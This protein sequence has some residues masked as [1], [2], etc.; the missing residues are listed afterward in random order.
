[1]IPETKRRSAGSTFERSVATRVTRP[2]ASS[3]F[4]AA[5]RASSFFP[6]S[7]F[8]FTRRSYASSIFGVK[9][10]AAPSFAT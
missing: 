6:P 2:C 9:A 3:F 10:G 5:R 7:S 4:T 1:M 8:C